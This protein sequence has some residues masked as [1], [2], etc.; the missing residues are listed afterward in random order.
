MDNQPFRSGQSWDTKFAR[1]FHGVA[2]GIHGQNS[3]VV[4]FLCAALVIGAAIAF[5]VSQVEWC[6]LLL[7]IT[8]V[9]S[10]ELFNSALEAL[11]RAIDENYNAHLAKGLDIAS[12]A[13]LWAAGGAVAV[14][15]IIFGNRTL[16][17]LVGLSFS[18]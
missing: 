1:A 8:I 17:L 16:G 6:L 18:P 3:F 9:F 14:G 11:A 10:A 2:A 15:L 5:Q 12:G 7:C 13:V 4:H